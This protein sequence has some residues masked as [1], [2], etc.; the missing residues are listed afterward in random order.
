MGTTCTY[1]VHVQY[2][3]IFANSLQGFTFGFK[4]KFRKF[5]NSELNE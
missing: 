2:L 3:F 1:I 5:L 4:D